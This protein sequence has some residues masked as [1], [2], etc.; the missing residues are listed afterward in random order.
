MDSRQQWND[1]HFLNSAFSDMVSASGKT[2][3]ISTSL[4]RLAYRGS[5]DKPATSHRTVKAMDGLIVEYAVPFPLIYIF[6]PEVLQKYGSIFLWMLQ[7]RRA[8]SVLERILVRD[9]LGGGAELKVFYAM[10][11]RLSWFVK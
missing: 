7:V 10:R 8:K 2:P 6:T 9:Q 5:K 3:W 11:S 4:V 1:F